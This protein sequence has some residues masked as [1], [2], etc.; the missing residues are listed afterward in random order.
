MAAGAARRLDNPLGVILA[1]ANYANPFKMNPAFGELAGIPGTQSKRKP[2]EAG[3]SSDLSWL[4]SAA[5][6][7]HELF[8]GLGC[9]RSLEGPQSMGSLREL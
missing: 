6:V 3:V 5:R 8:L 4:R 2:N 7:P 1:A 9:P